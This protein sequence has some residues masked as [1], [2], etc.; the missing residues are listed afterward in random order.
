VWRENSYSSHSSFVI[1]I[2]SI[3]QKIFMNCY[4]SRITNHES[5][6]RA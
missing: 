5:R 4:E 1:R 2:H 3:G 6:I